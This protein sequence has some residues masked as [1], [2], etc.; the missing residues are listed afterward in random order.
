MSSRPSGGS[1]LIAALSGRALAA[2]ARAAG[3]RP[4]VADLF[5]DL[6]T[7]AIA[8]AHVRVPGSLARGPKRGALLDALDRLGE[9]REPAGLV[10][11]S[12]FERRAALLASMAGRHALL[13]N[14]PAVVA[15]LA[16]P[17]RFA[18]MCRRLGVSHPE[19]RLRPAAG[20]G[21][22]EK[23]AGGAGGAHIRA[24]RSGAPPRHGHYLQRRAVGTPVSALFVSNGRD[25]LVLGFSE[26]WA[27]PLPERPFRYG[28]A[29][30]P[31]VLT[32]TTAIAMRKAVA[33]L[34]RACGL[35]GL[36]SADFLVRPDGFDLL[37][38][39]PRPGASLDVFADADGS[40]FS[41]HVEACRGR[42]PDAAPAW[43]DAAAAAVVFA[44]RRVTLPVGFVWPDWASDRQP[45]GL[46]VA[47]E[48]PLCTVRAEAETLDAARALVERRKAAILELAGMSG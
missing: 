30:R 4:L 12:G 13:G 33:Q 23:R 9:G 16:H 8:E 6:D 18:A 41:L 45:S 35:V 19:I 27:A 43:R 5:G 26:Q 31:A 32:G 40:V 37:E 29:V 46:P 44:P 25:S 38:I 10:Y 21:W 48:G 7:Q 14:S 1:I 17:E 3:Y 36:N 28:G 2:A 34:V 20:S 11:G 47:A 24:A 22:L 39:N 15:E 42:L